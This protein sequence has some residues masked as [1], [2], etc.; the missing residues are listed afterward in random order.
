[1]TYKT[2]S[3]ILGILSLACVFSCD[4]STFQEKGRKQYPV[5]TSLESIPGVTGEEIAAIEKLRQAKR[6]FVFGM[7]PST[8]FFI[9]EDGSIGGYAALL[10]DWLTTLFGMPFKPAEYEW[11]DLLAGL[12]SHAIDFTGEMTATP[13]RRAVYFMTDAIAE[14]TIKFMRIKGEEALSKIEK[15]RPLRYA[16]L[17]GT[18]TCDL[19]TPF[20]Q[21]GAQHVFAGN[22]ADVYRLLKAD[23]IDAFFDESPAEAAF[24]EYEDVVVEDFYPLLYSPVSLT[25]QNPELAPIIAVVQRALEHD[26]AYHLTQLYNRGYTA[27]LGHKLFSQLTVEEKIYMREHIASGRKIPIAAEYD[28]YPASFYNEPENQWQGIA[29]DV[30]KEIEK[31]TG[32]AFARAHEGRLEWA[33][34]LDMLERGDA[35]MVTELIPSAER[36]GRF[37]WPDSPY[38]TDFYALLSRAD[39]PN[40]MPNEILYAK[41]GMI[42]RS[43]YAEMFR[44]WFPNHEHSVEYATNFEA[45]DA[46]EQE[47]VDF[48]MMTQNQLLSVTNFLERPGFKANILFNRTYES[49]FGFNLQ[50]AVLCSIV[51]KALRVVDMESITQRWTHRLFDYRLKVAQAR[52][53]WLFGVSVLL[54]CVLSLLFIMFLKGRQIERRLEAAVHERTKQL[55]I[56]TETAEEAS[57]EAQVASNAKSQ[58]LARMSHEIRTP[59]NAVIGMT[60]IAKKAQSRAKIDASLHEILVASKHLLEIINDILDMS[61]IE[62]GKFTLVN[63]HFS[64]HSATEEVAHLVVQ[65]CQEKRIR[66][67]D[68]YGDFPDYEVKGDRLRLKQVLI[69]LIGNAVKFTPDGGEIRFLL[70]MDETDANRLSVTFSVIDTG[71]GMTESQVSKLFTVFEQTDANIAVRFGGTGLGL[72]I[73]QNLVRMMGGVITVQSAL[74][75]GSTFTFTLS[76]ERTGQAVEH[77]ADSGDIVPELLG[78]RIL[79]AEDVDINREILEELLADTHVTIDEAVDGREAVEKFAASP[80]RYYDLVFMDV[81]MPHMDGYEATR[82][83]RALDRKD[84]ALVPIIAMTANVY[85]DDIERGR[86]AGMNAHLAK[87]IDI[88]AVMRLLAERIGR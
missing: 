5:Y 8:E 21:Q 80:V 42:A 86:A 72:A 14:R 37:L 31:L 70:D 34:L 32:L 76:M 84:A 65:R 39:H 60:E 38:Q 17:E 87:P 81:Q 1:M 68:N 49:T 45:F 24:E 75:E 30:L 13:E 59:L 33:S 53:P 62:S 57:R 47:D 15:R 52:V 9:E 40:I 55:E 66:F 43:G 16:F 69:N 11:D 25:T 78:K 28:N 51:S 10:C 79:L 12:E 63:E 64:L 71:I 67:I 50:E 23:K 46:L 22:Y 27:Y 54:L 35:A 48:L 82:R 7:N 77:A 29:H 44:A 19:V 20:L 4:P 18:T 88:N 74:G 2:R 36:R 83:I 58:F 3:L 61:K 41:V 56:Q 6:A 73:S 85:S 26:G